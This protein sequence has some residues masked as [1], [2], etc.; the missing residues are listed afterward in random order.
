[1]ILSYRS[2]LDQQLHCQVFNT[3][4]FKQIHS[5]QIAPN[6]DPVEWNLNPLKILSFNRYY[7]MAFYRDHQNVKTSLQVFNI[8]GN[9]VANF[10]LKTIITSVVINDA[11]DKFILATEVY[12]KRSI[13]II[14]LNSFQ[15]ERI[16]LS[17]NPVYIISRQ[18]YF[19][20]ADKKG[21]FVI[22]DVSE[23][24]CS[25]HK[26]TLPED[27][28]VRAIACNQNLELIAATWSSDRGCGSLLKG[29]F[30]D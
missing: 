1:M 11:F 17:I 29:S 12:V 6:L 25:R 10:L 28:E 20:I 23:N 13:L 2:N 30:I 21:S 19:I 26:F 8:R 16:A 18:Q 4:N 9:W 14:N 24:T 27:Y 7:G 3:T 15:I 5:F 22:Y